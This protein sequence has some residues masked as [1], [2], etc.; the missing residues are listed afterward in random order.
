MFWA[1]EPAA[2]G[3]YPMDAGALFAYADSLTSLV[4]NA[5][6]VSVGLMYWHRLLW[7]LW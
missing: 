4:V 7:F 1:S 6:V 5:W 3:G 2:W